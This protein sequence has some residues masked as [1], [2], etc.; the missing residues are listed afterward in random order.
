[1]ALDPRSGLVERVGLE[2]TGSALAV[3]PDG[4]QSRA[5][6]YLEVLG[7]R[8][9]A[10]VERGSELGNRRLA[11]GEP[12]EDRAARRVGEGGGGALT[13]GLY[14]SIVI[15][16]PRVVKRV[17]EGARGAAHL[18][19]ALTPRCALSKL[20]HHERQDPRPA[21]P[22]SRAPCGR[23]EGRARLGRRSQSWHPPRP[24]E[25]GRGFFSAGSGAA[26]GRPVRH[27]RRNE[28]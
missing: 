2:P 27:E 21:P 17:K 5:L 12:R 7:D 11:L 9:L 28:S 3:L 4:N 25:T 22:R 26:P 10:Q 18:H 20:G 6:E 24:V 15:E 1:M 14:N 19:R 23:R 13:D 16:L 8:R